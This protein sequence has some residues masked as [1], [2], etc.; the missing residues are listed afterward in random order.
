[1]CG[2]Y[3]AFSTDATRRV[4]IEVLERMAQVL[5]HRGPDG[6]GRHVAG[7]LGMG[8]CRL[9]IIDLES[10]TQP[11]SNEDGTLWVVF[12]GEIYNYRELTSDLV[13]RGH[14]FTTASDTEVLIHLYEEYGER[15][16]EPLRG[17]F[18][19][20]IWDGPRRELLLARD[21]LGIKPLYYAATPQGV[22]FGSELKAL[23]QSPW[24]SPRLDGRGLTA[25]LQYGYVPDPLS[26]LEGVSKVPPG[27]TLRIRSGR[28][29]E[30]RRYWQPT[31]HFKMARTSSSEDEAGAALWERLQDAVRYHMVSDVPVG[32]FLSG[33][34]DSTAVV[35]IMARASRRPIKTFSVGFREDRYNELPYA[36]QVARACGTEHHELLVE[37]NDLKVLE[38]LLAGFDE[39]FADS[40]AIPTFLVSRLARQHVKVVLSGDGGDELFAGYDRYLVDRGR[41]RLGWAGDLGFGPVLRAIGS[42]LPVGGG[43]NTLY[44]LSLPRLQ[45]YIHS[46]SMF[47]GQA[48]EAVLDGG[49]AV[50]RVDV[51]PLADRELDFLSRLQDLD[52]K[53]YLPGDILTKVDRMSMANSL[54]ARVPLLDHPLVEFAC[55]LPPD[56][57]I[58]GGTAKYLLKRVLE[59]RVP[60]EVL[61]RAKQGFAV[62]L[63][64]WFSGSI[65]GFFRDELADSSHL[66]GVGIS[67][68]EIGRLFERFEATRRRDYCDRLWALVV[69]NRAVRR[70]LGP[71]V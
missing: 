49:G 54:E 22:L 13:A 63:E 68:P 20:A 62:P 2:I 53:T 42:L 60:A 41:R 29:D 1:M 47:P 50:S 57:R 48:L 37:P 21:R 16:V 52:L 69:L 31:D 55:S 18:A 56:L 10:G 5:A 43:K 64:S 28:P 66:A 6:E 9:S 30:P 14:R 33:G 15:C 45:R 46:I 25:Y 23:V 39:P 19:F 40:S 17:M 58:R 35:S 27:H 3:G 44:T 67:R 38:E 11:I 65:P 70:L 4:Q 26:I 24:L 71:R 12:N 7:P 8:M 36:R 59:G 61:T 32:A 34:V 51:T